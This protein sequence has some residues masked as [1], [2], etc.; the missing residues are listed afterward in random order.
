MRL[1]PRLRLRARAKDRS[2]DRKPLSLRCDPEQ[3]STLLWPPAMCNHS[4]IRQELACYTV[5]DKWRWARWCQEE[6]RLQTRKYT[7]C[8]HPFASYDLQRGSPQQGPAS[9]LVRVCLCFCANSIAGISHGAFRFKTRLPGKGLCSQVFWKWK[10]GYHMPCI[11]SVV[12]S[13]SG[14]GV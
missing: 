5:P 2:M 3:Y 11:G 14:L 12:P 9:A 1:R 13:D 10:P 4:C 7:D 6:A 8:L